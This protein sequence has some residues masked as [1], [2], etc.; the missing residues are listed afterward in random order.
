MYST[1]DTTHYISQSC[2]SWAT[3]EQLI[4]SAEYIIF[5]SENTQIS[6]KMKLSHSNVSFE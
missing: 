6:L 4:G 1:R 3:D 2:L 5:S